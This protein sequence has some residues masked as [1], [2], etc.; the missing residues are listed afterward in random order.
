MFSKK[1][2]Q[3]ILEHSRPLSFGYHYLFIG[4]SHRKRY[5][6]NKAKKMHT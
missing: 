4:M 5:D 2:I 3:F 1:G 6:P